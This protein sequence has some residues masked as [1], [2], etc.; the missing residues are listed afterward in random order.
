MATKPTINKLKVFE[1][2]SKSGYSDEKS[3]MNIDETIIFD[4]SF[5]RDELIVVLQMKE[6]AKNKSF[7]AYLADPS[8][9]LAPPKKEVK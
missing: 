6:A 3:I 2:L 5:S 1:K 8:V 9:D 4:K 7:I